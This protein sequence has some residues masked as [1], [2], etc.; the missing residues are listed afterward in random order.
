MSAG[1]H[2]LLAL[3]GLYLAAG[4]GAPPPKSRGPKVGGR[5]TANYVNAILSLVVQRTRPRVPGGV[6][7]LKEM[8]ARNLQQ[9]S[10]AYLDKE[11]FRDRLVAGAKEV[12]RQTEMAN[13]AVLLAEI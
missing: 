11:V 1:F 2:D 4:I 3:G 8:V 9:N 10:L 12:V 7:A 6:L 13:Q 5:P